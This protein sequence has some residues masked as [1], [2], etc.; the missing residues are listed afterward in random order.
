M[1]S[2][3]PRF[4]FGQSRDST[5]SAATIEATTTASAEPIKKIDVVKTPQADAHNLSDVTGSDHEG[6]I[7]K[8]HRP[9][10][11]T[12]TNTSTNG[13]DLADETTK[14]AN[15]FVLV[16]SHLISIVNPDGS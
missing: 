1:E 9:N 3:Q 6:R 11:N 15:T 12:N 16:S 7:T 4:D 8:R 2:T 13:N 10:T 14:W 5:Q